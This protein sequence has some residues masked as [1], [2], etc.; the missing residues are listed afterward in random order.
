M[1][2]IKAIVLGIVQGATE[3]FPV[4]SSGHLVIIPFIFKW[5]YIP[6]Y[7]AVTLH[8]ATL[9][10]LIA[11]F[12]R[13]IGNIM[14]YFFLGI[15]KKSFRKNGYF[16]L[17]LLIIV[18]T[19]PAV[20]AGF[21]LEKYLETFFS[22]PLYVA[23]FLLVTAALLFAGEIAGRRIERI[24]K[25]DNFN[26]SKTLEQESIKT[27]GRIGYLNAFVIGIGQAIAI[28]PGIS[29][30]GAT[31]SF[32]RFFGIKRQDCVRFSFL[33]SIPVVLGAFVFEFADSYKFIAGLDKTSI[34]YIFVS[35]I[36]AFGSGFVAIKFI[37][38]ISRT[39]N[40]NFFAIYCIFISIT[41][42]M[43]IIFRK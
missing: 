39:R 12:Y 22:K 28:F 1:E 19:I 36:F 21:F 38:S 35:F 40:L 10:A 4:S 2:I 41:T 34:F 27:A 30:S 25:T 3:F 13:E 6:V 32:A 11:V 8:F 31:I 7:Y 18:A 5:D 26:D 15:F 33:L 24:R 20:F 9:I 43:L 16:R 23:A 42:F 37:E 29:R 14:K 17:S